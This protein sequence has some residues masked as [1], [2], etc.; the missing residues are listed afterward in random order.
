MTEHPLLKIEQIYKTFGGLAAVSNFN[1]ELTQGEIHGIIGPNGAGKTTVFNLVTGVY[2]T[3]QGRLWL[4]GTEITGW[5]ADAIARAGIAR[6]FQNIRLFGLMTVADNIKMAFHSRTGYNFWEAMIQSPR[7][8]QREIEI[9][10][11]SIAFLDRFGLADRRFELAKNLPYG[12]QRRLE[13]ARA[14]ATNPRV[15]L[16]DEPAAGMNPK[17]VEDLIGLIR[18]VHQDFDLAILLIE[19][20]MPLVMELCQQIQVMDFGQTIADGPPHEVTNHPR[21]IQAYLGEEEMLA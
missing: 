7:Y 12:E 13:I 4:N 1:L 8:R 3:D 9:N 14:L 20:Q 19:H 2:P 5:T 18:R 11:E 10:Q 6:T 16:L 17:E 15:L 21:V